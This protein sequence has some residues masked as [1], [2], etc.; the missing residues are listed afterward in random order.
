MNLN[1][2]FPRILTLLRKEQGISQKQAAQDL[3]VPQALL[4]HYE[5]GIREP[6]LGFVARAARY[7]GVS[8]DYLLG[9]SPHRN[10]AVI[11][12]QELPCKHSGCSGKRSRLLDYH[13][14][15]LGGSLSIVF[16]L[17]KKINNETLAKEVSAYLC[18]AVYRA[19]RL[20]YSANPRNLQEIFSL[21]SRLFTASVDAGMV[22]S[23]A[24]ST[25]LLGGEPV[26][27][28]EGVP[29]E[30]LP[31]LSPGI[32]LKKYPRQAPALFELIRNTEQEAQAERE[33][34]HEVHA[35]YSE[36]ELRKA[37]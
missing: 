5:R 7:Y 27:D 18:A 31:G 33:P 8:C 34:L 14:R 23:M 4:S 3:H 12:V 17:L 22:L 9:C 2:E 24:K 13:R 21:D 15:V 29:Q 6:G 36:G 37:T 10:G 30:A 32:L 19:F 1:R 26:G 28:S 25:C 11:A 16:S 20:L 35:A